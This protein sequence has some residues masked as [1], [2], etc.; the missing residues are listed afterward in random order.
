MSLS[1]WL[2]LIAV[3][4]GIGCLQVT[5][6]NALFMTGYA[7]GERTRAVHKEEAQLAWLQAD[8][9]GLASPSPLARV[10]QERQL[11]LVAWSLL[12]DHSFSSVSGVSELPRIAQGREA[13]A[14]GRSVPAGIIAQA[15]R[16]QD[17]DAGTAD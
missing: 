3:V 2:L 14:H 8:V 16:R 17:T 5:Q 13:A 7:V 1:R 11:K 6:H 15:G 4:M 12:P 9:N 10:A